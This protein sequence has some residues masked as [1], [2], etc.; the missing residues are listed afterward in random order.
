[1][2][3]SRAL[4]CG[5][6]GGTMILLSLGPQ[7]TLGGGVRPCSP[8][9]LLFLFLSPLDPDPSYPL[10]SF[11]CDSQAL[12]FP[13]GMPSP[14]CSAS[15]NPAFPSDPAQAHLLQD[16]FLGQSCG[17]GLLCPLRTQPLS[18]TVRKQAQRGQQFAQGQTA[19][20]GPELETP[21]SQTKLLS[22]TP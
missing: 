16:I 10:S 8:L 6:E 4:F 21:E 5:G 3:S 13:P 18:G 15:V 17:K 20:P 2:P 19:K 1:M 7:I 11:A 14:C 9:F 22:A 12:L